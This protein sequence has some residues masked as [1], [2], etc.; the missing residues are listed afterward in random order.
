QLDR[1]D[2]PV[3]CVQWYEAVAYTRWLSI[4][5]GKPWRL[6]TEAEWEKAARWDHK[7][8][9]SHIYPWGDHWDA[10]RC[11]TRS[12]RRWV[13]TATPLDEYDNGR[14][15]YDVWDMAGNV[16]EWT[17][18]MFW[19]YPYPES[20]RERE[21]IA[22]QDQGERLRVLRGGAWLL[23]PRVARCACRNDDNE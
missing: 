12:G 3:V 18:S 8:K 1:L 17:T 22:P 14:S 19:P 13:G 9:G 5:T 15:S 20:R 6:P 23:K 11:N 2:H 7:R 21:D 10:S 16:W 4:V